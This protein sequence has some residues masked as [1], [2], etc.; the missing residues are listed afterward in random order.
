MGPESKQQSEDLSAQR[1]LLRPEGQ[2]S[3]LRKAEKGGPL[4]FQTS[5]GAG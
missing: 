5:G 4:T 2:Y 1:E 3:A